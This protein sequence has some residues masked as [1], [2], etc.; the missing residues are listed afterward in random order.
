MA[1][2]YEIFDGNFDAEVWAGQAPS[3]DELAA[4][5]NSASPK[6]ANM[7]EGSIAAKLTAPIDVRDEFASSLASGMNPLKAVNSPALAQYG[8]TL[9]AHLK[10]SSHDGEMTAEMPDDLTWSFNDPVAGVHTVRIATNIPGEQLISFGD[11]II[12]SPG[13]LDITADDEKISIKPGMTLDTNDM[14]RISIDAEAHIKHP[15]TYAQLAGIAVFRSDRPFG[16]SEHG[17][18][19][20]CRTPFAEHLQR[21]VRRL[22]G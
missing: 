3:K 2:H 18:R 17:F 16:Q 14:S 6:R 7:P 4:I 8:G 10:A 1:G 9:G 21:H 22:G 19:T 15:D 11:G 5:R 20:A 13:G 12:A